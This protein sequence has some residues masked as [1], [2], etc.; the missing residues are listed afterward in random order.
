MTLSPTLE[1]LQ[2]DR[3]LACDRTATPCTL[4]CACGC[5]AH[6][7]DFAAA[8]GVLVATDSRNTRHI[9]LCDPGAVTA[10]AGC[11]TG[12]AAAPHNL[13]RGCPGWLT[14]SLAH[15]GQLA[16]Y[17]RT[18]CARRHCHG[19]W[20]LGLQDYDNGVL[21]GRCHAPAC[22][23]L[24]PRQKKKPASWCRVTP[25]GQLAPLRPMQRR[26]VDAFI[27]R[28]KEHGPAAYPTLW[29]LD[30]DALRAAL[31][32]AGGPPTAGSCDSASRDA[33]TEGPP[34]LAPN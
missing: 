17:G 29:Q 21:C 3:A 28:Y 15:T 7:A 8:G 10:L 24:A 34:D 25:S 31:G 5:T 9:V 27:G 12:V 6:A 14:R 1:P 20:Q 13:E 16:T 30:P 22:P 11:A 32:A 18:V 4:R 23:T 33:R 19:W 26:N 2:W